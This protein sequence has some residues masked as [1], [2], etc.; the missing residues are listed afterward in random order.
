MDLG[1]LH[2]LQIGNVQFPTSLR[3]VACEGTPLRTCAFLPTDFGSVK[4]DVTTHADLTGIGLD[5]KF[6]SRRGS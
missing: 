6:F 1:Y 3:L 5:V 2:R 4:N